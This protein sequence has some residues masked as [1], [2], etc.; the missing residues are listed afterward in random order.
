MDGQLVRALLD[1]GS[2]V[3]IIHPKFF[4]RVLQTALYP[5][6]TVMGEKATLIGRCEA[7]IC[8]E[9]HSTVM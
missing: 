3:T 4:L 8:V 9:G 7:E 6:V 1:T 5:L 2:T